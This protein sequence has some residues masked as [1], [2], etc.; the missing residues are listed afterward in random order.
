MIIYRMAK[1]KSAESPKCNTSATSKASKAKWWNFELLAELLVWYPKVR[2]LPKTEQRSIL[3]F[4][5][6][7][8]FIQI[9]MKTFHKSFS[10]HLSLDVSC[11]ELKNLQMRSSEIFHNWA[12]WC[13][14]S[15]QTWTWL[16]NNHYGII[17]RHCAGQCWNHYLHVQLWGW[18]W[19]RCGSQAASSFSSRHSVWEW[20]WSKKWY[21][22]WLMST[23][24]TSAHCDLSIW[25]KNVK[26]E[27]VT[28]QLS[29]IVWEASIF[30]K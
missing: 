24:N 10:A 14:V 29:N 20:K 9:I 30:L 25:N 16:L 17:W 6:A 19:W 28:S 8:W 23:N 13:L 11:E 5:W 3:E 1:L 18:W 12:W 26:Y 21:S 4:T 15:L 2:S 27:T 7:A 22:W